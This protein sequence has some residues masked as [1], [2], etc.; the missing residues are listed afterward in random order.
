MVLPVSKAGTVQPGRP[1][2]ST[3][4]LEMLLRHLMHGQGVR[5]PLANMSLLRMALLEDMLLL[6]S[7]IGGDAVQVADLG[8]L[9]IVSLYMLLL[10]P[11]Q[12]Y[13]CQLALIS[14]RSFR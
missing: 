6:R 14:H 1:D 3:L 4:P 13:L 2:T 8:L 12:A 5:R 9:H 10:S 11:E 7:E